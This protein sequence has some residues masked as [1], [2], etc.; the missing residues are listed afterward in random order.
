MEPAEMR[1]LCS[2][3]MKLLVFIFSQHDFQSHE[4]ASVAKDQ[5]LKKNNEEAFLC[6][7]YEVCN[8]AIA[9]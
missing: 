1:D 7:K 8:M 3:E 4:S 6:H 2:R 5:K 9:V